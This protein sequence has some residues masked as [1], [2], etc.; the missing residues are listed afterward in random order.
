MTTET[1]CVAQVEHPYRVKDAYA[2]YYAAGSGLAHV[3]MVN[4]LGICVWFGDTGVIMDCT[5]GKG[6]VFNR[7]EILDRFQPSRWSKHEV[8]VTSAKQLWNRWLCKRYGYENKKPVSRC[9]WLPGVSQK[10]R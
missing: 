2:G 1:P 8:L 7:H 5:T 6:A 3:E 10:A 4:G 9:G